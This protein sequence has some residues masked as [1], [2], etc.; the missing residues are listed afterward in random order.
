MI[1]DVADVKP[2][3]TG[4][5]MKSTKTPVKRREA[6]SYLQIQRGRTEIHI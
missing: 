5:E 6:K 3:V 1:T 2:T 4:I